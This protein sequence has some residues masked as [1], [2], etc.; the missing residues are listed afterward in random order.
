M[1][2]KPWPILT[3]ALFQWVSPIGDW[4]TSSLASHLSPIGYLALA[5]SQ[6][7]VSGYLLHSWVPSIVA[8]FAVFRVKPWSYPLFFLCILYSSYRTGI[9][10]EGAF[11][12]NPH[13]WFN[14]LG[15]GA[16]GLFPLVINLSLG[17]WF[18]LPSVRKPFLDPSL[19]WWEASPRFEITLSARIFLVMSPAVNPAV[20]GKKEISAK[21][22]NLS[23]G[24]ALLELRS[25]KSLK[26][27]DRLLLGFQATL[28]QTETSTERGAWVFSE[29]RVVH[30]VEG[31]K[32]CQ[33]GVEFHDLSRR[34]RKSLF[35]FLRVCRELD[36][37]ELREKAGFWEDLSYWNHQV[38]NRPRREVA[39][40]EPRSLN[41][42]LKEP[43]RD[44][45]E[46]TQ[47]R[48]A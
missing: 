44:A 40:Q 11:G 3:L 32:L 16:L 7:G 14:H 39:G 1:N 13:V 8:G 4:L 33:V 19:R 5:V 21:I 36:V 6:E 15:S 30:L 27:G 29:A 2:H 45:V 23:H 48:A 38:R 35:K 12:T 47:G 28:A 37:P 24:G 26:N 34:S 18:L 25:H 22:R 20:N 31:A 43:M 46:D 17:A 10:V 42:V 9:S 41:L